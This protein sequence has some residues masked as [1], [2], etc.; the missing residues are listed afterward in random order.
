MSKSEDE[1]EGGRR[2][3]EGMRRVYRHA[4]PEW[5]LAA[6]Q[7]CLKNARTRRTL[8]ADHVMADIPK[9]IFIHDR[10]ALGH[11]MRKAAMEGWIIKSVVPQVTCARPSCHRAPIQVWDSLIFGT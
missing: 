7:A 6:Q 8:T 10:R 11:V 3:D 1:D 5:V 4:N 9:T 2:K